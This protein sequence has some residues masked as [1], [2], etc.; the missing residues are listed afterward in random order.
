MFWAKP[1]RGTIA[2]PLD[3]QR[4]DGIYVYTVKQEGKLIKVSMNFPPALW[5]ALQYR[6][7]EENTTA[8]AIMVRL[9]KEYLANRNTKMKAK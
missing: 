5:K 6:A 8:T 1:G 2:A 4:R 7:L 3:T 9:A